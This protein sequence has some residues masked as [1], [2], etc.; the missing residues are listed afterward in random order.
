MPATVIG[1]RVENLRPFWPALLVACP[2]SG[3]QAT[4][5]QAAERPSA[6]NN[7]PIAARR[8]ARHRLQTPSRAH[9]K[10]GPQFTW[11]LPSPGRELNKNQERQPGQEHQRQN[12]EDPHPAARASIGDPVN[13]VDGLGR[14]R[15][16]PGGGRGGSPR[17][18]LGGLAAHSLISNSTAE[19]AS[20]K[21]Y[22][23]RKSSRLSSSVLRMKLWVISR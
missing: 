5:R 12:N 3:R 22:T 4:G 14:R 17:R 11:S 10:R 19:N 2:A 9:G 20:G 13:H 16:V 18:W 1:D 6:R 21:L 15:I 7:A 8:R 23:S